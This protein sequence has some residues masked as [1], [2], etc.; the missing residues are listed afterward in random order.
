MV[1]TLDTSHLEMS[2]LNIGELIFSLGSNKLFISVTDDTSHDP[3]GPREPL[4]QSVDIRRHSTK[5]SLSSFLD[6][7]T[8]PVLEY[9]VGRNA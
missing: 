9:W 8:N 2:A 4:E 1:V 6:A 5:A 7:G 3:M